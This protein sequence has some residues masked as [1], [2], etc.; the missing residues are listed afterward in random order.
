MCTSF[1]MVQRADGSTHQTF[2]DLAAPFDVGEPVLNDL[3]PREADSMVRSAWTLDMAGWLK[4]H[5]GGAEARGS[6]LGDGRRSPYFSAE[7]EADERESRVRGPGERYFLHFAAISE[8]HDNDG[9]T[10]ATADI[11]RLR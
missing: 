8:R 5:R 6:S 9:A 4:R 10:P 11:C 3:G 1:F 7:A 2:V